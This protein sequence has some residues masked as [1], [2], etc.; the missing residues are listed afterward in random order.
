MAT[1]APNPNENGPSRMRKIMNYNVNE[2]IRS[3][4]P[5]ENDSP[6]P[7]NAPL[8]AEKTTQPESGHSWWN[9]GFFPVFWT[10]ASVLSLV[11]NIILCLL[12]LGLLSM[13]STIQGTVT[14]QSTSLLGGLYNNFVKMD[15]ATIRSTI[16]VDATIPLNIMVP[17]QTRT[18]IMLSEATTIRSPRVF[19]RTGGLTLDTPALVTLPKD[20]PL[21]VDLNFMLPVQTSVPVHLD[22]P[23]NIPLKDTELHQPFVG[24]Q[25]V[26]RPWY[27]LFLPESDALYI[28]TCANTPSPIPTGIFTP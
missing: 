4:L 2:D 22:V 15:Q 20:Q 21:V 13:R 8:A 25:E 7:L 18:T 6:P 5:Q 26:V 11:V 17:V 24:L 10:I 16:P 28:Q 14:G 23:V 12:V 1:D 9:S 19:I 3:K 27:C